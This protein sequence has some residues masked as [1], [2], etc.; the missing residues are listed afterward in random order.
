M[1]DPTAKVRKIKVPA[2]AP[3]QMITSAIVI[4]LLTL[5]FS[6]YFISDYVQ[7]KSQLKELNSLRKENTVQ[8]FQLQAFNKDLG[9]IKTG[10]NSLKNFDH[11]LRVMADLDKIPDSDFMLGIGGP[12]EI[13]LP[14]EYQ[15]GLSAQISEDL[16]DLRMNSARQEISF[17]ELTDFFSDQ[18]SI[19]ACTPSIWP[20]RGWITSSFG[21]RVDPFTGYRKMHEGLDVATRTG[22]PVIAPCNGIVTKIKRDYGY[23]K[24]LEVN[25]GNG[26]VTRYG[27]N[28]K[29][30]VRVGTRVKRGDLIAYV[31]NTGRS[32]GP[33]LHYEVIVN[34]VHVNPMK[35]ILN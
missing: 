30:V 13:S 9:L 2:P 5:S 27:H 4:V 32:T 34:G 33:H 23:G 19:L 11:K 29:I 20:V 18:K 6:I 24:M 35:Y 1:S 15:T 25:S 3:F 14:P 7:M 26:I 22:T 12:G 8:R 10:L 16:N 21:R 28:S 17:Q 31:G